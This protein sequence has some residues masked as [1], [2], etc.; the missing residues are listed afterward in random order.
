MSYSRS[1]S[2]QLSGLLV[3]V[4]HSVSPESSISSFSSSGIKFIALDVCFNNYFYIV[5]TVAVSESLIPASLT[6]S[7]FDPNS[8]RH[9]SEF[10]DTVGLTRYSGILHTY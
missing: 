5:V 7:R 10:L 3:E 9:L 1:S 6:A 8:F 4:P 2:P